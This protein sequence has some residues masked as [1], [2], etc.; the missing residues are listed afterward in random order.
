MRSNHI[1]ISIVIDAP[2]QKVWDALVDWEQQGEWMLATK[3]WVTSDIRVG[4]G[5][6]I[7]ALTGIGKLGI[8]D[9]MQVTT[10]NPPFSADVLHTGSLIKGTGRFELIST[11]AS[12]T[13]FN[14]SEEIIAP[15]V[16]FLALWPGIY[17]GVRISLFSFARTF[18]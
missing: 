9:K 17:S 8:L 5:T 4:V 3:I 16:V 18:R 1:A 14:W 12:Q 10:W 11:S 7:E 15:R 13:R 2:I 6:Q